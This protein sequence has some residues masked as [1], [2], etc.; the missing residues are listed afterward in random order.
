MGSLGEREKLCK[1]TPLS[2]KNENFLVDTHDHPQRVLLSIVQAD[3]CP[4]LAAPERDPRGGISWKSC[5]SRFSLTHA[6]VSQIW[7]HGINNLADVHVSSQLI[8]TIPSLAGLAIW[9]KGHGGGE[10]LNEKKEYKTPQLCGLVYG[11]AIVEKLLSWR[12]GH[13]WKFHQFFRLGAGGKKANFLLVASGILSFCTGH[14]HIEQ[15]CMGKMEFVVGRRA[16]GK[17]YRKMPERKREFELNRWAD[18]GIFSGKIALNSILGHMELIH[19]AWLSPIDGFSTIF[20][21]VEASRTGTISL[22]FHTYHIRWKHTRSVSKVG[23]SD[24]NLIFHPKT[25]QYS[26]PRYHNHINVP[27]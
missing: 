9:L 10:G 16:I 15:R 11:G 27:C 24:L 14:T 26:I 23:A 25:P 3:L 8:D 1:V 18:F 21:A 20:L 13:F 4:S 19:G 12:G 6:T 22:F 5:G 17:R 2:P 7:W